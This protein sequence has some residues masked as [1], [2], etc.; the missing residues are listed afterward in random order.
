MH[1]AELVEWLWVKLVYWPYLPRPTHFGPSL[2]AVSDIPSL[3]NSY[4]AVCLGF[5]L[6][7]SSKGIRALLAKFP[8]TA[9]FW[10]CPNSLC[11]LSS[12][13]WSLLFLSTALWNMT[14]ACLITRAFLSCISATSLFSVAIV[15]AL[16]CYNLSLSILNCSLSSW[17]AAS[18][19]AL[20]SIFIW[21]LSLS[22]SAQNRFTVH[23]VLQNL[24]D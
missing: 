1:L 7:T 9:P 18:I 17:R 2:V 5:S 12:W 23:E 20:I 13:A 8:Q 4:K 14:C 21:F 24:W 3:R 15:L 10:H 22:S 6:I 16:S 19:S 11:T